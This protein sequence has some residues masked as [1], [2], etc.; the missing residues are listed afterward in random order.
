M[1][2]VNVLPLEHYLYGVVP[3][4]IGAGSPPRPSRRRLFVPEHIR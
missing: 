4:E 3:R 1:T 2:V